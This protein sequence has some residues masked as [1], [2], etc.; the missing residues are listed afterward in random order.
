MV[1]G[2]ILAGGRSRRFGTDKALAELAGS[3]LLAR[4]H[5]RLAASCVQVAVS[6]LDPSPTAAL[7]RELG[8]VVLAD[9]YGSPRGPLAGVLAGLDWLQAAGEGLLA[10]VPCED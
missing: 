7:A 5:V 1:F 3:T 4:A 6:A 2:L 10:T 9:P 8:A